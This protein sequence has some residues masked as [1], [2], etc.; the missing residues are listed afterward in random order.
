LCYFGVKLYALTFRPDK[1]IPF[2]EEI[3]ITPAILNDSAVSKEVWTQKTDRR[4]FVDIIYINQD[5]FSNLKKEKNS[6]LM[7]PLRC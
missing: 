3:Q 1:T 2:T 5:F 6:I 4:F 7:I